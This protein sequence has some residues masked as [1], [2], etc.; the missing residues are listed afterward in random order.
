VVH[1]PHSYPYQSEWRRIALSLGAVP[2]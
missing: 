2:A 1:L